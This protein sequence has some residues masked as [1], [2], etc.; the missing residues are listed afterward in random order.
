MMTN[1]DGEN[2]EIPKNLPLLP[3]RD[4]VVFPYMI[5]PLFVGRDSSIK[6]VEESLARKD[7][8]ILLSSQKDIS[9]E[10]PNPD[11]IYKVGTVAMIMRMRKLPDGRIKILTQ[12]LTKVKIKEFTQTNPYFQVE[13]E[14]IEENVSGT[15]NETEAI[16]RS[17]RE[18][19][20]RIIS[21]GKILS[22]DIAVTATCVRCPVFIG[23]AEAV[24]IEFEN[25][26]SEEEARA[27][28][29]A[30]PGIT[31]VDHRVEGGYVTP[32][33]SAGEDSIYVSR[34]R[35]DPTVENGLSIWVV[36]DNL[37]KGAALN[38]VQIAEELVSSYLNSA[39]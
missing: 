23:H 14:K 28:L 30:T 5:I 39:A 33:E 13:V 20:E 2:I 3:V 12:G 6:S 31:V 15:L 24:N 9:D 21:L 36:A 26:I 29:S 4:I 7:R 35:K 10:H 22:P 32:Q 8:L 34:I 38:T 18:Q 17:V 16:M 25:A 37:R 27:E 11:G 1:Y 19:L